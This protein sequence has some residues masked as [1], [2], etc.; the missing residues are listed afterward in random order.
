MVYPCTALLASKLNVSW[1]NFWA[2][3]P[4]E[5]QFTSILWQSNR[6][7][8]IP[9]PL[10]YFP[11]MDLRVTSQHL[12][13]AGCAACALLVCLQE[14]PIDRLDNSCSLCAGQTFAQRL[15]NLYWFWFYHLR[16]DLPLNYGVVTSL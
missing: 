10:A 11:Q 2:L 15:Q 6:R 12:V 5:P 7:L 8:F 16:R 9:N 13:G 1:V 3:S 4:L 14:Q